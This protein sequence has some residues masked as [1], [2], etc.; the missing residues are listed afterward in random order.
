MTHP[1]API[2]DEQR[3]ASLEAQVVTLREALGGL[4]N[5]TNF[6]RLAHSVQP[7]KIHDCPLCRANRALSASADYANKILVDEAKFV[8]VRTEVAA[9]KARAVSVL[10]RL[11]SLRSTGGGE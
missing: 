3:I 2:T 6:D 1:P 8:A 11:D 9:L 4:V 5:H 10:A 7:V